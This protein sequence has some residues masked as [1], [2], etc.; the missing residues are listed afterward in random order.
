MT[1][2]FTG[3]N[4]Y[5]VKKHTDSLIQKFVQEHGTLAIERIDGDE[6]NL[7]SLSD[8]I[9]SMPFLATSKLVVVFN[10]SDKDLLSSL[11]EMDVPDSTQLVIIIPKVDKRASYYKKLSKLPG[12]KSFEVSSVQN[13]PAWVNQ[14][15][16]DR[17]G[18]I[19]SSDARYLVDRVGVNQLFISNEIDKLLSYDHSITR[20]SIDLLC[21][22]LPQT[23]VF[24]LLDAAFSEDRKS[25]EKIYNDQRAQKVEPHAIL[26]MIAWQLHVFSLVKAAGN[27]STD[28]VAKEARLNPFVVRKSSTIAGRLSIQKLESFVAEARRVDT[29]LKT[30]SI[31]ADQAVQN[32][33]LKLAS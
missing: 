17:G 14:T 33:L 5:E 1:T 23:S 4:A 6:T 13:L 30:T 12:F 32:L 2:I 20:T 21:D 19:T 3:D 8:A 28:Q 9:Q 25:M 24:Q 7:R 18:T 15:V 31:D 16:K 26:G 22:P 10:I 11:A 29:Q 27:R